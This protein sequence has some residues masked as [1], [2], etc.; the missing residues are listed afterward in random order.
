MIESH[1]YYYFHQLATLVF[2]CYEMYYYCTL[3]IGFPLNNDMV[4]LPKMLE[5]TCFCLG[6][7]MKG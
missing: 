7:R 6:K 4:S 5:T 3:K 1:F 2:P